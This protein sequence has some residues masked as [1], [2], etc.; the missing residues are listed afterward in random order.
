MQFIFLY[1]SQLYILSFKNIYEFPE[2]LLEDKESV[3]SVSAGQ[4]PDFGTPLIEDVWIIFPTSVILLS[5]K[6]LFF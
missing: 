5:V 3:T 1:I 4:K 2:K 6:A